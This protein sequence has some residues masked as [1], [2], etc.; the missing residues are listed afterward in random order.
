MLHRVPGEVLQVYGVARLE[1]DDYHAVL[2]KGFLPFVVRHCITCRKDAGGLVI[3]VEEAHLYPFGVFGFGFRFAVLPD[4][5]CFHKH[6]KLSVGAT[7]DMCVLDGTVG[8]VVV[9]ENLDF[10]NIVTA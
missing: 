7:P 4:E 10:L 3:A 9:F 2:D 5:G 1:V 8:Q 6:L